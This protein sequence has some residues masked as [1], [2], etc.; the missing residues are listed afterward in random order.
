MQ[1]AFI[2]PAVIFLNLFLLSFP[3]LAQEAPKSL[4]AKFIN[5][6]IELDGVLDEPV[7]ETAETGSDFVQF[8]PTDSVEANHAT[9]IKILY[10]ETTL[11]VGVRAE[12]ANGN[13]VVSSL[14]RDFGAISNDNV[15]LLFDTFSDGTTAYFFGVTP[16]GV[17]REGLVA[18]GG[19]NFNNTWDVKWQA[20]ATRFDDHFVVEM[21][22]PFTS[23]KFLEGA[24]QWRFRSYRW[25]NQSNEQ[26]TWVR[27]PQNQLLSSLAYMGELYFE[28]PLGKSRTPLTLIPYVNT[29]TDRDYATKE[30]TTI[31]KIGGDAKVAIGNS[32]NLDITVNPDF[33]NVEVDDIFTNLTRFE[34]RLPEK[35]QFFIDNSDL[36]ESFGNSFNESKPFF[37]RRIGLARDTSGNLIQNDIIAG[38]RLSGKLNKDWRLGI[39]NIQ[40]AKDA[41]NEIASFNNMM[42]AVQRKVGKRSNIGA[43]WVNRQTFDDDEEYIEASERYNR[44]IGA[45]YN[46]ASVDDIWNG[47]FYLHKSFQP[48]D[49]K[50]NLSAQ[51]TVTYNPREWR[52]T[53]DLVYIDEG[54][55][56]DLGFVPRKDV[57]KWGNDI[58]RIFYPQK[59][60]FNTHGVG[61]LSVIYWR[62]SLD[63]KKTD[64]RYSV[65]WET[66]F[67]NQA[68]AEASFTNNFIF[69]TGPF[70]PTRT[71]GANPIQ[72]DQGYYFNQLEFEYQSNNTN[73]LTYGVD[74]TIGGFFNGDILSL[75]GEVAYRVQ[76]WAQFSLAVNY[77]GIRL[78]EPHAD[79]DLWLVTPRLE[80]TF[81]KSLFWST[82]IQYSNQ[83]NNLGINSRLQ[84]RFAPLSDLYLVYNDN[85]FTENFSP[86]F[87]SINLK[88][89]YWLNL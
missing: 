56:A 51:A 76:P 81:S 27:V 30:S 74:G 62:P 61:F 24:T 68:T 52:I 37:S 41:A 9:S 45:D 5:D 28:R 54:F 40:T 21:A 63:Y 46:L 12:A 16:Y 11:Y 60:I 13:Y 64:H 26:S 1:N 59:G 66:A 75:G 3:L 70:D 23:L 67:R 7:W 84:W 19:S 58:Q 86:R 53:E 80:I 69:L 18:E 88:L 34:L 72:G 89:T 47:R 33:S 25:N 29:Q 35:R 6:D 71:E 79:A 77:D 31:F 36:F 15:S 20:E 14:R 73:L 38:A 42:L 57:L 32:M 43:F 83:R 22:I 78:P 8:F 49:S 48:G 4:T 39:L 2:Y 50:G 10:S 44:V 65:S 82:L 85:Y 17:R 55:R 87:R